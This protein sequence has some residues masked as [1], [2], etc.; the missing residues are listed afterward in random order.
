M[1]HRITYTEVV[2]MADHIHRVKVNGYGYDKHQVIPDW[3]NIDH[4]IRTM[5]TALKDAF[6]VVTSD[7]YG[8]IL[9]AEYN[10]SMEQL[11]E[12]MNEIRNGGKTRLGNSD[13]GEFLRKYPEDKHR[14]K[15]INTYEEIQR[16][17]GHEEGGWYYTDYE[18]VDSQPV[19]CTCSCSTC[20][21]GPLGDMSP[22]DCIRDCYDNKEHRKY[23]LVI[24]AKFWPTVAGTDNTDLFHE[25][26][27]VVIGEHKADCPVEMELHKADA[28]AAN[29]GH[30]NPDYVAK[31]NMDT[32]DDAE[33]E[34]AHE[35]VYEKVTTRIENQPALPRTTYSPWS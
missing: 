4:G 32:M 21:N 20:E 3:D 23:E 35:R 22:C 16:F 31:A 27:P 14:T 15:Y 12:D 19:K 17:G 18:V 13:I 28:S 10:P 25:C 26:K 9:N 2:E 29:S 33:P 7:E 6:E 1:G 24:G 30:Y 34:R 11:A 5:H 8:E